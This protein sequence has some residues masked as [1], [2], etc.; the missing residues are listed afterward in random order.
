MLGLQIILS[1]LEKLRLKAQLNWRALH[2]AL[3]W[4]QPFAQINSFTALSC[5]AIPSATYAW[6]LPDFL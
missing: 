4:S 1:A 2:E 5:A 3:K 6:K